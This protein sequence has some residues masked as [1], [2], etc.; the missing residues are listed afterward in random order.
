MIL[1]LVV[2]VW[3]LTKN[4]PPL[5]VTFPE[6]VKLPETV[7]SDWAVV[8]DDNSIPPVPLNLTLEFTPVAWNQYR[9]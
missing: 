1:S 9:H 7:K 5:A 6:T 8:G 4:C 3:A 2:T